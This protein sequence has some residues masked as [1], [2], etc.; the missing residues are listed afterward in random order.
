MQ[1]NGVIYSAPPPSRIGLALLGYM[2]FITL[3]ITLVPFRFHL[4]NRFVVA[5]YI[6]LSDIVANVFFFIPL[7]FF[8]QFTRGENATVLLPSFSSSVT[9]AS[10]LGLSDENKTSRNVRWGLYALILGLL[11]SLCIETAQLFLSGRY[12]SYMDLLANGTGAWIGAYCYHWN[13]K[14]VVL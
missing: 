2:L 3:V 11:L 12:S 8:Y 7:G 4:P 1:K 6:K 10:R 14:L 5:W 13:E 9:Q